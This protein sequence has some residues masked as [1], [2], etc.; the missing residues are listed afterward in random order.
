MRWGEVIKLIAVINTVNA[1][2]DYTETQTE[3]EVFANKTSVKRAE[4][5]QAQAVGLKP[6]VVFEVRLIDYE[7][8]KKLSYEGEEYNVIREYSKDGEIVELVCNK[9]V[10]INDIYL[11]GLTVTAAIL[12]P[13]FSG[14]VYTY[15][16][17]VANA[18]AS[19]A[20]TPT[21]ALATEI[22]VNTVR[23]ESG[24]ASGAIA[25]AVGANVIT[26]IMRKT[27]KPTRTYTITITRAA[28]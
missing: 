25:L 26:I 7:G 21:G 8:E 23:V 9:L 22:T 5:Y 27:A 3:R 6:E 10:N 16:S 11:T 1:L 18:V 2:G 19:V 4:F 13:T 17:S 28:A 15:T 14:T 24:S 12:A 20:V